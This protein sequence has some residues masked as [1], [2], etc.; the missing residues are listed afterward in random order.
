MCGIRQSN[1]LNTRL[2]NEFIAENFPAPEHN[3]VATTDKEWR[4]RTECATLN[5]DEIVSW[6]CDAHIGDHRDRSASVIEDSVAAAKIRDGD[7]SNRGTRISDG[8]GGFL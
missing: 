3:W 2:T 5:P 7:A 1:Q 6:L 4:C 8:N